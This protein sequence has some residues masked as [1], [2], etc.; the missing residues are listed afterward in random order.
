MTDSEAPIYTLVKNS[1][2]VTS[3]TP[4]AA[5]ESHPVQQAKSDRCRHGIGALSK[6]IKIF[7]LP[8]LLRLV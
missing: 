5:R 1:D 6:W 2:R 7:L 8:N 3:S 4:I